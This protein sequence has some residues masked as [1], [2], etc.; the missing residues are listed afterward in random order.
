MNKQAKEE[1]AKT[2][3]LINSGIAEFPTR[4]RDI[5]AEIKAE[6][7]EIPKYVAGESL[8]QEMNE[9]T[10]AEIIGILQMIKDDPYVAW[11]LS[12]NDAEISMFPGRIDALISDLEAE[13]EQTAA[14]KVPNE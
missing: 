9:Q 4:M 1:I 11:L 13:D 5:I 8:E 2:F 12:Y 7:D 14:T 6:A 3:Q 10:K